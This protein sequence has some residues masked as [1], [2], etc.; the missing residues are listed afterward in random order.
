M[1]DL[2][3][4]HVA[5]P[6]EAITTGRQHRKRD[7]DRDGHIPTSRQA[8]GAEPGG[9]GPSTLTR[10]DDPGKTP[11]VVV[12]H[13][14]V[15]TDEAPPQVPRGADHHERDGDLAVTTEER[16]LD[17]VRHTQVDVLLVA[18]ERV[19]ERH[20][21]GEREHDVGHENA[22]TRDRKGKREREDG[23]EIALVRARRQEIESEAGD[24]RA[25]QEHRRIS[26]PPERDD[27]EDEADD[28]QS[29]APNDEV[30]VRLPEIEEDRPPV[31]GVEGRIRI[32]F[33]RAADKA[34]E[35]GHDVD[36]V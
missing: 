4:V 25:G 11:R 28:Q 13:A 15:A 22:T 21:K 7:Q 23:E 34:H 32:R 33:G 20:R 35:L 26:T 9:Q 17:E 5:R 14:G 18:R 29:S 24:D 12:L 8:T 36:G 10:R 6:V 30:G 16:R 31:E 2:V 27:R 1:I 3:E 19:V